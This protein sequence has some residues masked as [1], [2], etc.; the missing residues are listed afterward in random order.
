MRSKNATLLSTIEKFVCDYSDAHS[1]S[2]SFQEIAD[3]VG[4]SLAT[5]HRYVMKLN[6]DGALEYL[7]RRRVSS[8]KNSF[9]F[10][11]PINKRQADVGSRVQTRM[12]IIHAVFEQMCRRKAG[13]Q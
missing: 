3:G 11:Q 12:G 9:G 1:Y 6:E 4:V 7:G 10:G 8:R 2:P 5:A 13:R